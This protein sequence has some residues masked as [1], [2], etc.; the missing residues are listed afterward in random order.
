[1][2]PAQ[3]S[4]SRKLLYVTCTWW[5][6]ESLLSP[7][8][9]ELKRL[10]LP[11]LSLSCKLIISSRI[12]FL[13]VEKIFAWHLKSFGKVNIW[14]RW[15]LIS[16]MATVEDSELTLMRIL[17]QLPVLRREHELNS[18]DLHQTQ[19][20]RHS[21]SSQPWNLSRYQSQGPGLRSHLLFL[22]FQSYYQK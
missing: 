5:W 15:Y 10:W 13:R 6:A 19:R 14:G 1:M 3:D 12:T 4:Q 8:L 11:V 20:S 21:L 7:L 17:L 2:T 16:F 9:E 22:I 18:I